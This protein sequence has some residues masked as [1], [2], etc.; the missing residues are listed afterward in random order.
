MQCGRPQQSVEEKM[1]M[2]G[3]KKGMPIPGAKKSNPRSLAGASACMADDGQSVIVFGGLE[4]DKNPNAFGGD[5]LYSD[6]I[7]WF[8][9]Q[10]DEE[11][12]QIKPLGMHWYGPLPEFQGAKPP[13]PRAYHTGSA[14][15]LGQKKLK[16]MLIFG[17][18]DG[19][20]KQGILGDTHILINIERS[21]EETEMIYRW[22]QEAQVRLAALVGD[23]GKGDYKKDKLDKKMK[24]DMKGC[25][26]GGGPC[27][28][29][30]NPKTP[31]PWDADTSLGTWS[32][33]DGDLAKYF[34]KGKPWEGK[35]LWMPFQPA[36]LS[37]TA[38]YKHAAITMNNYLIVFGGL[39]I[40]GPLNDIHFL[41]TYSMRWAD[42]GGLEASNDRG[43]KCSEEV[44]ASRECKRGGSMK[45]FNN[46]KMFQGNFPSPRSGHSMM[47]WGPN[48][49]IFGGMDNSIGVYNDLHLLDTRCHVGMVGESAYGELRS[50]ITS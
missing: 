14:I 41:N 7:Y 26:N 20:G 43:I 27:R 35:P 19:R 48:V 28:P 49:L 16:G 24:D 2:S 8:S 3:W 46:Q 44:H 25:S 29:S 5:T 33:S 17:G 38:R 42:L 45:F 4:V 23:N 13:S 22:H 6:E 9:T 15:V 40:H 10:L 21:E 1:W 11:E 12:G 37:P 50:D 36:G 18:Y 31:L 34:G 32:H 39:G 30:F 47:T